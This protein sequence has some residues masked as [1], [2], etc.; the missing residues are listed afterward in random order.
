MILDNLV[1]TNIFV[2]VKKTIK[3]VVTSDIEILWW[4]RIDVVAVVLKQKKTV[5]RI[6]THQNFSCFRND[7]FIE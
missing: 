2:S 7:F 4:L 5:I 3:D 1:A 6:V